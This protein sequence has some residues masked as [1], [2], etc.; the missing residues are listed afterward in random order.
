[1]EFFLFQ[2]S[3]ADK[4]NKDSFLTDLDRDRK[5]YLLL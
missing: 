2:K 4:T 5:L 3:K 1:M